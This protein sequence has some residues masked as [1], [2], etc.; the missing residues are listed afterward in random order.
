M[1]G[2]HSFHL[3]HLAIGKIYGLIEGP[4]WFTAGVLRMAIANCEEKWDGGASHT[5]SRQ[6]ADGSVVR[7]NACCTLL[8]HSSVR[9]WTKSHE[10]GGWIFSD[11][12]RTNLGLG[13]EE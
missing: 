12:P 13:S 2:V 9:G 8:C 6:K 1:P 10:E 5:R 7:L 3:A 11:R 4:K